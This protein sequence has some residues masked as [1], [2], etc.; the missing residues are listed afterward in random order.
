MVEIPDFA[1]T[2]D[3]FHDYAEPSTS[4]EDK[5]EAAKQHILELE[6]RLRK[7]ELGRFGLDRFS[8]D[9]DK[10]K[11]YTGFPNYEML[12]LFYESIAPH[13]SHMIT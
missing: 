4:T 5:L 1:V 3:F 8:R 12:K 13:A 11:F 9:P 6:E 2:P 7:Q 10:L